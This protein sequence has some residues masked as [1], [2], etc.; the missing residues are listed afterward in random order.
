VFDESL[1]FRHEFAHIVA[2]LTRILGPRHLSLAEEVA[3]DALIKAMQT[4][5]HDGAP[6]NP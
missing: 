5:P 6:S 1:S 4:W 3:Q 2:T